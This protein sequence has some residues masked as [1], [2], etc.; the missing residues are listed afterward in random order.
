MDEMVL[1][2][3]RIMKMIAVTASTD[4][5]LHQR[6]LEFRADLD[7]FHSCVIKEPGSLCSSV[8]N[9]SQHNICVVEAYQHLLESYESQF[10]VL[11]YVHDDVVINQ[12]WSKRIEY[13]LDSHPQCAIIGLGGATGLGVPDIYKTRYQINQLIRQDYGSNQTDWQ[14]HGK[15]VLEPLR[16]AVVDGFFMAIRTKFLREVGGW[17]VK[18]LNFHCYDLWACLEAARR[19]YEVWTLPIAC[20]HFGGGT[21][22]KQPYMDYL[23]GVGRTAEED[24]A[25]PHVWIYNEY[26][27]MLPLRIPS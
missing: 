8:Y 7:K 15:Q 22:T 9:N 13:H 4:P 14:V 21:S 2:G 24:H 20:T 6:D 16:V 18:H 23:K 5:R 1:E 12:F 3:D 19:G 25:K 27:D 10:D 26:R 17:P 11:I